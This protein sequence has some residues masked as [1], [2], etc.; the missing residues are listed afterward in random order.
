MNI[1]T[2]QAQLNDVK[3][4]APLFDA[5]RVFYAQRSDLE[6]AE[7][8]IFERLTNEESVVFY[9][10]D[11]DGNYLGFTQLYPSFSSVSAKRLWIL[12]DLFVAE[13]ARRLGVARLLMNHAKVF[14]IDTGA[15][16][17]FL[18]TAHDNKN[19]QALYESLGYRRNTE[20]YYFL[21]FEKSSD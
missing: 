17:L 1:S 19:G 10:V 6:L 12:N 18:E 11:S 9:A 4:I 14:A 20:Y 8:F 15:K 5:Y 3:S 7:S 16:G 21:D 2:H 13:E